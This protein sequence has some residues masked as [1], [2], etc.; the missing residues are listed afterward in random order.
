MN[1]YEKELNYI[2]NH[3]L[4]EYKALQELVERATPKKPTYNNNCCSECNLL[5]NGTYE[6]EHMNFCPRCGQALKFG[7]K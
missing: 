5:L 1:E 6:K 2:S 3:S 7:D 4:G